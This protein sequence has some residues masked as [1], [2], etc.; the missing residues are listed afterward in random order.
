METW[1]A[2]VYKVLA[3]LISFLPFYIHFFTKDQTFDSVDTFIPQLAQT[4]GSIKKSSIQQCKI[5]NIWRSNRELQGMQ[6]TRKIKPIPREK[7]SI[8]KNTPRHKKDEGVNQ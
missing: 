7:K 3:F 2:V 8:N 4:I 1:E 5:H 6:Q